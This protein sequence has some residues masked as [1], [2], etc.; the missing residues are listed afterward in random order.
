MSEEPSLKEVLESLV[1]KGYAK[2]NE[3]GEYGLTDR[4]L[5]YVR[6]ME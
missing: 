5:E 3:N 4:G 1:E 6:H 2:K